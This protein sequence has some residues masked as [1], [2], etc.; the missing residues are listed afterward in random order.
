MMLTQI[1]VL[2]SIYQSQT[3]ALRIA[4]SRTHLPAQCTPMP[5]DLDEKMLN[6]PETNDV[7]PCLNSHLRTLLSRSSLSVPL[8]T[9]HCH[10]NPDSYIYALLFVID[11]C[12]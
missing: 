4:T 5:S 1:H 11:A 9:S 6:F 3:Q 2:T 7:Y 12:R 10:P 8:P